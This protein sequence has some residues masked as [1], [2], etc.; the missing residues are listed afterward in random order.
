MNRKHIFS[1]LV[2]SSFAFAAVSCNSN[3][4]VPPE[5]FTL[6]DFYNKTLKEA[7]LEVGTNILFET[8]EVPT[9]E[10]VEGRILSYGGSYKVGDEVEKGTRVKV[11]VAKRSES[12]IAIDN[13]LVKY[14]NK[15]NFIT[16]PESINSELLLNA[17][18]GGTDL[19]IPFELPDGKMMLLYGDT[20]SGQNMSGFWNSNFMAITDDD[21]L[22]D[23]LTFSS[24]VKSDSGMIKP[25]FQGNHQGGNETDSS[26]EVTKI[27]TG[28][29]SIGNDVYIF[30]MSIRFWGVAGAWNV[31]YNEC[32]KA[33][34]NTY[35][36]WEPVKSL[37]WSE[38]DLYYA[39]QI[40]PFNNP[41][42]PSNIYFVSIPGGRNDGSV[43]FRVNKDHF[44]DRNEYEYLVSKST[45]VKGDEGMK[46]L[47]EDPYYIMSPGVSEPS[48]IYSEY[49]DKFVYST[50]KG[51]SIVF[52]VSD[53][54]EGPYNETHQV[55]KASDFPSL[56]GGFIHPKFSDTNGQ[57]LYLQL[58]Q[59]V[60]I[61]NTS[62]I[63]VVLN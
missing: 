61:Y 28:G 53:K 38:N 49:L 30:Y 47:N 13:D 6:P 19:G 45:W 23:G 51:S 22:S 32:I 39:G 26:V 35:K 15:I 48:I 57:R 7:K 2:I 17:G 11:N 16:G 34:D 5:L 3:N 44:E 4:D 1:I 46:Q 50:L 31:N 20:F 12:A 59:W 60:P 37:K 40:Y 21:N 9:S 43:M 8:T 27:P 56:Y 58:S 29:I 42:D 18:A 25:F 24:V 62:L 36:N 10:L 63:E 55:I 52:G 33:T 14:I 41:K 54:V